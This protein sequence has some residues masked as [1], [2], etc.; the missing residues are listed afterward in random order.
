MTKQA[1]KSCVTPKTCLQSIL[2]DI[3]LDLHSETTKYF[4]DV[5]YRIYKICNG[6]FFNIFLALCFSKKNLLYTLGEQRCAS[7]KNG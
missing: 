1:K 6:F 3:Y 2:V 5:N 7:N 4:S